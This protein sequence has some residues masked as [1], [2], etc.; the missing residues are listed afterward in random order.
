VDQHDRRIGT[1]IDVILDVHAVRRRDD[2]RSALDR[3]LCGGGRGLDSL[4]LAARRKRQQRQRHE[5]RAQR[6]VSPNGR[7]RVSSVQGHLP[8]STKNRRAS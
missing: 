8:L 4:F 2:L 7:A 6:R 1:A 5:Q 3:S